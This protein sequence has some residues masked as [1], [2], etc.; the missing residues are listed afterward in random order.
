MKLYFA[1]GAN[2][3]HAGM[4][5]RCPNSVKVN[6]FYLDD[7]Q[8]TFSGVAS[9]FPKP[10]SQVAGALWKI[11]DQCEE[12]LDQFEGHPWLY[13]KEIIHC[14]GLEFMAYIM[15]FVEPQLPSSGYLSTIEQ[16]YND[17]NLDLSYLDSAVEITR[18]EVNDDMYW[19]NDLK[20]LALNAKT[21]QRYL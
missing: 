15:N 9:I 16:G 7:W 20:T 21:L 2:L 18:H 17:W 19:S 13:R 8:L 11:T 6:S 12:S 1:Y 5:S 4:Q 3:N 10:G 14:D